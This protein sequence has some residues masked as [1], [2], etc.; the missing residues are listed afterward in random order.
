M[1]KIR[2]SDEFKSIGILDK[3]YAS[4][5]KELVKRYRGSQIK[6]AIKVNRELLRYYWELGKDIE[7]NRRTT[8]MALNSMP[9]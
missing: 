8:S 6:A 3:D 5:V 9:H 7:E 1:M 4:W 2:T